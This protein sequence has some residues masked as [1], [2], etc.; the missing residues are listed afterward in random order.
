[1]ASGPGSGKR[2][3]RSANARARAIEAQS[4]EAVPS[5]DYGRRKDQEDAQRSLPLVDRAAS[6][7][8]D[9]A[10]ALAAA[11]Q[12]APPTGGIGAPTARP[13]E[14]V[15]AG[16]PSGPGSG[17]EALNSGVGGLTDADLVR[18]MYRRFPTE[19]MRKLVERADRDEGLDR[20]MVPRPPGPPMGSRAGD[21]AGWQGLPPGG[22]A[23]RIA[24]REGMQAS[25]GT[26]PTTEG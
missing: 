14:P 4:V 1:M 10:A 13:G 12:A 8:A 24:A 18:A 11:Q 23:G 2:S 9:L 16:L 22:H 17:P 7:Q 21:M 25:S 19:A 26:A 3:R 5:Q 20:A 6:N 15:T